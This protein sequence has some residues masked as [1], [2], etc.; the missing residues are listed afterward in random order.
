[1]APIIE[2]FYPPNN[3]AKFLPLAPMMQT[4]KRSCFIVFNEQ[5]G[6]NSCLLLPGWKSAPCSDI[7]LSTTRSP[8]NSLNLLHPKWL[9]PHC[10]RFIRSS[11][12]KALINS[13]G[14]TL[15]CSLSLLSCDYV[16][17]IKRTHRRCSH[18][19]YP[20]SVVSSVPQCPRPATSVSAEGNGVW[21]GLFLPWVLWGLY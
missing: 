6:Y 5:K 3:E 15:L 19:F 14:A 17:K 12:Y 13:E 4:K 20:S 7:F 8:W 1:M 9:D 10:S 16:N 18:M 21:L 11:C 2:E